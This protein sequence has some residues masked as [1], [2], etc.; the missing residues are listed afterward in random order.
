MNVIRFDIEVSYV[1]TVKERLQNFFRKHRWPQ[2]I[3]FKDASKPQ[4]IKDVVCKK[5]EDNSDKIGSYQPAI[6]AK[7]SA[8]PYS[9]IKTLYSPQYAI[10]A[11][12]VSNIE[13]FIFY[14]GD[15]SIRD[16]IT[17]EVVT[18]SAVENINH[19]VSVV[20][21]EIARQ[22]TDCNVKTLGENFAFLFPYNRKEK[23]IWDTEYRIRAK[24]SRSPL[25]PQEIV[26]GVI[27][28]VIAIVL[29][30]VLYLGNLSETV[31]GVI[32]GSA[33]SCVLFL[34]TEVFLKIF[35][36]GKTLSISINNLTTIIDDPPVVPYETT[37]SN[38]HN[39]TINK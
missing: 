37:P 23:D 38:L 22:L 6:Q 33:A 29:F 39:P 14:S 26:R 16:K 13:C 27:I 30:V 11:L 21:D 25:S 35:W 9:R 15:F 2:W 17:L 8:L 4:N 36:S 5:L 24:F 34:L 12:N 7:W 32:G 10:G 20:F 3:R 31:A 19:I 1:P 28:G 18:L